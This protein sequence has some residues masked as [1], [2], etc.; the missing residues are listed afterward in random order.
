[1]IKSDFNKEWTVQNLA[2][3]TLAIHGS[4]GAEKKKI[5][6]PHDAMILKNVRKEPFRG[7][8]RILCR[9]RL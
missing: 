1:M 7:C 9:R 6:L 4:G 8:L 5:T 2:G 3:A